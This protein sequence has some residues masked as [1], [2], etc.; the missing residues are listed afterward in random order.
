MTEYVELLQYAKE[1]TAAEAPL[2]GKQLSA[3]RCLIM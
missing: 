2:E 1:E 3:Y